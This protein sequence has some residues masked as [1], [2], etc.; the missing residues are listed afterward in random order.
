MVTRN[1]GYVGNLI[2]VYTYIYIYIDVYVYR[3]R[4]MFRERYM[5]VYIYIYT[6][7]YMYIHIYIYIHT[8]ICS[9]DPLIITD[10]LQAARSV[11]LCIHYLLLLVFIIIVLIIIHYLSLLFVIIITVMI[12]A[13]SGFTLQ[14]DTENNSFP[15]LQ[16]ASTRC[17]YKKC[18][19]YIGLGIHPYVADLPTCSRPPASADQRAETPRACSSMAASDNVIYLYQQQQQQ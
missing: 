11:C 15:Y 14:L 8:Q 3:D 2:Y 7:T 12:T 10:L 17:C 1:F 19:V 4:Y 5:Y 6:Y 13:M 9:T 18:K 16:L